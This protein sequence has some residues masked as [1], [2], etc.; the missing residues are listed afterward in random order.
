MTIKMEHYMPNQIENIGRA[1]SSVN[2][3]TPEGQEHLT[4]QDYRDAGHEVLGWE[5]IGY[6]TFVLF[7]A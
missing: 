3:T 7:L 2:T 6:A 1:S 5:R 4:I